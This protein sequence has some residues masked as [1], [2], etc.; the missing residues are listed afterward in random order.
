MFGLTV[1][2][3]VLVAYS[4]R[5]EVFGVAQ[6]LHGATLVVEAEFRT[7]RLDPQQ[8][9]VDIGKAR[10]ALRGVLAP[11]DY[12]NLD[13]DPVFAGVNTTMEFMA[14][15]IHARLAAACRSGALGPAGQGIAAIRVTVREAPDTWAT[16]EAD[17]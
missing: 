15:H 17:L 7:P 5:G 1:C 6:R 9:V 12:T 14:G 3:R 10:A 11:L 16:Y 13:D 2:D 8:I 4:L